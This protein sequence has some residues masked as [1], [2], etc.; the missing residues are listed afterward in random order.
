MSMQLEH[1]RIT[2]TFELTT[3]FG[4]DLQKQEAWLLQPAEGFE[5]F[6]KFLERI[7]I[8]VRLT[9]E[10]IQSIV[11]GLLGAI[12]YIHSR[13]VGLRRFYPSSMM[14]STKS[15]HT[16]T[17][18]HKFGDRDIRGSAGGDME[19]VLRNRGQAL[20][21]SLGAR[22]S[23]FKTACPLEDTR[24]GVRPFITPTGGLQAAFV[25][26]EADLT[27]KNFTAIGIP[28]SGGDE[29]EDW[30][31][32]QWKAVDIWGLGVLWSCLKSPT[33]MREM[34]E[35]TSHFPL[36]GD[37]GERIRAGIE[38]RD[39]GGI[40]TCLE[41]LGI[42]LS[43][44][45]QIDRIALQNRVSTK[46]INSGLRK[47]PLKGG[48]IEFFFDYLS[49]REEVVQAKRGEADREAVT[50]KIRKAFLR[51]AKLNQQRRREK[52]EQRKQQKG[53]GSGGAG[54]SSGGGGAPGPSSG[55]G[56]EDSGSR[57]GPGTG[58]GSG[59]RGGDGSSQSKRSKT[60]GGDRQG[61]G[62]DADGSQTLDSVCEWTED[63]DEILWEHLAYTEDDW[64]EFLSLSTAEPEDE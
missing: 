17:H 7:G 61:K 50:Q 29:T 48:Q 5:S 12:E 24:P 42:S 49:L 21:T 40:R 30:K 16:H 47:A 19:R 45:D 2:P 53:E 20:E 13:G 3:F 51:E 41:T 11:F 60:D 32:A 58:G 27:S 6:D 38:N 55:S 43:I 34:A 37:T 18:T 36:L 8:T 33:W 10:N 1:P 44:S 62:G 46:L 63:E 56:G 52:N 9:E 54:G 31:A 59:D 22:P 14:K 4:G 57:G 23:D 28:D 25:P 35:H 39:V 64:Q 15:T 26:P